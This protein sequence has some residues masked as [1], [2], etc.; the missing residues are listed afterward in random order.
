MSGSGSYAEYPPLRVPS[1][2]DDPRTLFQALSSGKT[3]GK[4]GPILITATKDETTICPTNLLDVN[5]GDEYAIPLCVT[6]GAPRVLPSVQIPGFPN[7]D[8]QSVNGYAGNELLNTGAL[9]W[10][11]FKATIEWGTGGVQHSADID[12]GNGAVVNLQASFVRVR[13][14]GTQI[15]GG[16]SAG[17]VYELSASVSPGQAKSSNS[18]T[19]TFNFPAGLAIAGNT[20]V[21]AVP[22][23]AK[24]VGMNCGVT[25][26]SVRFWRDANRTSFVSSGQLIG[27]AG[28]PNFQ[29]PI[30]NG[31][32]F[33]DL[34]N[35]TG[36][37]TPA[38]SAICY[39]SI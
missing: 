22:R 1:G 7:V 4:R 30:P 39:L 28:S 36:A 35:A 17:A 14:R 37:A 13:A 33:F 16:V 23:F 15:I 31:A 2:R 32:Y 27:T 11:D 3:I 38:L 21:I 12:I 8:I 20:G 6:L 29:I 10:P 9:P 18:N 19:L 25:A 26:L 24:T 34:N 5:G